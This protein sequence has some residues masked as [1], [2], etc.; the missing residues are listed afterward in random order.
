M[1]LARVRP[2]DNA[3]MLPLDAHRPLLEALAYRM[4]GSLSEAEE[5]VQDAFVRA[6]TRPPDRD[7]PVRPWLVRVTC[8]LARDRLRRRRVRAYHGP[9]L[10][11]PVAV[12]PTDPAADPAVSYT[13]LTLP[14]IQPV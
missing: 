4:L 1:S 9:W 14:T 12:P 13:H 10:P 6:L 7:R 11:E 3:V 2:G 5:V 8:N